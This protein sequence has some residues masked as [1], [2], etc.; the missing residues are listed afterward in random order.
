MQTDDADAGPAWLP[1][2][3]ILDFGADGHVRPRRGIIILPR[4]SP[5]PTQIDIARLHYAHVPVQRHLPG[6]KREGRVLVQER[7]EFDVVHDWE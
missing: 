7:K 2:H 1:A 5:H 3:H 4:G 6:L